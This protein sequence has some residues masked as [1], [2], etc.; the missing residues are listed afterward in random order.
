MRLE[1]L[2]EA[3]ID[4][5]SLVGNWDRNSS[6]RSPADRGILQSP[7][8][9]EK[10]K[11]L[12]QNTSNDFNMY[13][14]NSPEA[15]RYTEVGIVSKEWLEENMPKTYPFLQLRDDQINVIFTNNK[16]TQRHPMTAWIIAHRLGHAFWTWSFGTGNAG[17]SSHGYKETRQQM[18]FYVG[19]LASQYSDSFTSDQMG[20]RYGSGQTTTAH[21]THEKI[22][23]GLYNEIGTMKSARDRKIRNEFEFLHE[24]FAQYIIT[25]SVK[26]NPLPDSIKVGRS[27]LRFKGT[28]A[29]RDYYDGI[30]ED[31]AMTLGDYFQMSLDESVGRIY[32]M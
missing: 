10:I 5:I 1:Q 6:F 26:F 13:M 27:T 16:A 12:W 31:L 9:I 19:Q 30:L 4:N 7:K 8:G 22:F 23:L 11:R 28:E 20:I 17:R 25:G 29:D 15:N 32:V 21:D 24:L 14:V 2:F 3:P 18:L